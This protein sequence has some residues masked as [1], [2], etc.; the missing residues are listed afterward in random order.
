M[1]NENNEKPKRPIGRPRVETYMNPEWY[2]IMIDSGTEGKHITDFLIKLGISWDTH[3]ELLK[4]NTAY[5][6]AFKEYQ[7]LCENWWYN[8]GWEAMNSETS[9]KFNQRLWA[10]IMSNKFRENWREKQ[11]DVTTQGEKL[12]DSKSIQIEIIKPDGQD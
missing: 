8:K 6:E 4:R 7:K 3:Y 10:I 1:L 9:N 12:N 2:K 11:I 5:S